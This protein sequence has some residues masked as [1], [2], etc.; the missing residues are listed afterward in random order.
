MSDKEITEIIAER[1][2]GYWYGNGWWAGDQKPILFHPLVSDADCMMAWDKANEKRLLEESLTNLIAC[3]LFLSLR[4]KTRRRAM[5][6][7]MV[8]AVTK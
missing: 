2:M 6:R 3:N 5:C 4:G 8:K 7:F 1:V